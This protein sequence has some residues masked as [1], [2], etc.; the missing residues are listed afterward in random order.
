MKIYTRTGDGGK[1][2]LYDGRRIAKNCVVF[3]VLGELDELNSRI[4][5]ACG[6]ASANYLYLNVL[7]DVQCKIQDINAI[8]ATIDKRGKKLPV[9]TPD[10]VSKLEASIDNYDSITPRLTKFIIPGVTEL[11]ASI[12][13]CRTQARKAE[14]KMWSLHD[15]LSILTDEKGNPVDLGEVNI[16]PTILKYVNRLSDF[17]FSLARYVCHKS[18][19]PDCFVDDFC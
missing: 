5:V 8:I 9:I 11:D 18:G 3:D 10:D 19:S 17:F 12:H 2:S 4:G 1:T 16:D 13:M 14:R 7:R 6:Y 15:E